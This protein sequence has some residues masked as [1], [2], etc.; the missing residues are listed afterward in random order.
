MMKRSTPQFESRIRRRFQFCF[1]SL[2]LGLAALPLPAAEPDIRR[3]ATVLA[4]ER[5]M[6]SVVNIAT[7]T[8][9]ERRGY[10]T[11]WFQQFQIPIR[12]E[13]QP[14]FS[15]GSGV[16]ID[17]EGIV[18]TNV[19]VVE[20]ADE[21]WVKLAD[22]NPPIPAERIVGSLKSDIALLR[23]LGKAGQKFKAARFAADPMF[24]TPAR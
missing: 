19:H 3:D 14:Q 8:R 7:K 21:I 13:L 15:A 11:D 2:L 6:P 1:V 5:I 16:I 22:N 10:I 17:E 24:L 20:E 23:L 9:V 4:V 18:M 12:Q